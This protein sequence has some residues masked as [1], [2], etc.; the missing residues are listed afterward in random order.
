MTEPNVIVVT[1]RPPVVV[2]VTQ[3]EPSPAEGGIIRVDGSRVGPSGPS[4]PITF[5]RRGPVLVMPEGLRY[6]FPFPARLIGYSATMGK[7]TPPVG[8]P[9]TMDILLNNLV[10]ATVVIPDGAVDLAEV[11]L[12]TSVAVGDHVG[13]AITSVGSTSPGSDLSLLIRYTA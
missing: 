3:P 11:P 8:S 9:I 5:V 7:D 12:T 6:R 2:T 1:P 10:I 13:V 4:L